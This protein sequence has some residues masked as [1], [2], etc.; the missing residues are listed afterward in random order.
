VTDQSFH[1]DGEAEVQL[2][3]TRRKILARWRL[4]LSSSQTSSV[5]P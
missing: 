4:L 3:V 5:E 2:K 1:L